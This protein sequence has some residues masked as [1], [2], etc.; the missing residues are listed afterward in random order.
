MA[1]KRVIWFR[2]LKCVCTCVCVSLMFSSINRPKFSSAIVAHMKQKKDIGYGKSADRK[3]KKTKCRNTLAI[4][5][6]SCARDDTI[7]LRPLQVDNIFLFIR[8]VAPVQACLRHQQQVDLLTL[9]VVSESHVTWAPS[10][11]FSLPRP[12]CSRVRPD[13][14]DRQTS[15]KSIA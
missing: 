12:L 8:Q 7:C 2:Y 9:K 10:A 5:N 13:I 4:Q 15:D 3:K 11:N 14:R 6:T 1:E